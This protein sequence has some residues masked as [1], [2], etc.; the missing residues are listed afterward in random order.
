M[1]EFDF[2]ELEAG[3]VQQAQQASAKAKAGTRASGISCGE[4]WNFVVQILVAR[5]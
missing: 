2:E 3:E 5:S 4:K 1:F